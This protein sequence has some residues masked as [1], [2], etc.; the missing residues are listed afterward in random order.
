MISFQDHPKNGKEQTF[1]WSEYHEFDGSDP[2]LSTRTENRAFSEN[3][4]VKSS[5]GKGFKK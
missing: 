4:V 2:T 1:L 5:E 3:H